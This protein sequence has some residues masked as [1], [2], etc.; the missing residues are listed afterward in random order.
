MLIFDEPCSSL[1]SLK[2]VVIHEEYTHQLA[3]SVD[4]ALFLLLSFV[5]NRISNIWT[6]LGGHVKGFEAL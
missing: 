1:L 3:Q 4:P 5:Q 2:P 6:D